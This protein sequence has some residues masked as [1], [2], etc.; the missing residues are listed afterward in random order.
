M[1][2]T[3]HTSPPGGTGAGSGLGETFSINLGTGTA[4]HAYQLPLP[5]GVAKHTPKLA[6][7][8]AH[9]VGLG[10]FGLGW[11]LEPRNITVGLDFGTPGEDGLVERLLDSGT[12]IVLTGD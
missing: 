9:S 7:E 1:S 8:Y 11:R 5:D 12:E 3:Q 2:T 4:M 10:A 6:L